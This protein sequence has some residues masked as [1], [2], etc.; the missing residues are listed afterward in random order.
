MGTYLSAMLQRGNILDELRKD[1]VV[2][3]G[4]RKGQKLSQDKIFRPAGYKVRKIAD[5]RGELG[6]SEGERSP[7]FVFL[8]SSV[9]HICPIDLLTPDYSMYPFKKKK[10]RSG[11][12]ENYA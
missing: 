5:A 12:I 9:L 10:R 7:V 4:K 6:R 11:M 1:V 2:R 3:E 8:W